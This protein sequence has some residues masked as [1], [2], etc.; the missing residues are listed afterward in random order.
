MTFKDLADKAQHRFGTK[1]MIARVGNQ[2]HELS[3]EYNG[4]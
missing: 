1:I 3:D 4:E 2:Y